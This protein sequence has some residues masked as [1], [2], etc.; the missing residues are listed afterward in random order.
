MHRGDR[1][2][3]VRMDVMKK[4][5]ELDKYFVTLKSILVDNDLMNKPGQIFS[6]DEC[7]MLLEHRSPKVV[8]KKSRKKRNCTA[9][10]KSQVMT[11]VRCIL[12]L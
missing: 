7:G 9:G 10:N 6:V 4:E 1:T 5:E 11:V 12:M 2:A 8:A 3:F